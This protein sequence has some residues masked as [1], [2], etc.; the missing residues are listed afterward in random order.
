[1]H[2]E[3]SL[4]QPMRDQCSVDA[5]PRYAGPENASLSAGRS[6]AKGSGSILTTEAAFSY[7]HRETGSAICCIIKTVNGGS[8]I[9]KRMHSGYQMCK[10]SVKS[11]S[12]AKERKGS[13]VKLGKTGADLT[14]ERRSQLMMKTGKTNWGKRRAKCRFAAAS[15][16]V[17]LSRRH[18]PVHQK[19]WPLLC[20]GSVTESHWRRRPELGLEARNTRTRRP[21]TAAH[22]TLCPWR[23][24]DT[25]DFYPF[26]LAFSWLHS[27][28]TGNQT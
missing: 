26:L 1:M 23:D 20:S 17:S 3:L 9:R 13:L 2:R 6:K 10:C 4:P 5:E 25:R 14:E 8:R 15:G 19:Q 7:V 12:V 24:T 11:D 18:W 22:D 16:R 21:L 27:S 28:P